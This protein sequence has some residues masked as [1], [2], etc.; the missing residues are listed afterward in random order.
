MSF[1]YKFLLYTTSI[2]FVAI[3]AMTFLLHGQQRII[4]MENHFASQINTAHALSTVAEEA[5]SRDDDLFALRYTKLLEETVE[6][7]EYAMII[8]MGGVIR[9]HSDP[10]KVRQ[11]VRATHTI[12][13]L[14]SDELERVVYQKDGKK[15]TEISAPVYLGDNKIGL[16]VIGYSVDT[17]NRMLNRFI[18]MSKNRIY[19]LGY[20]IAMFG[21]AASLLL[22]EIVV[23]PIKKIA[24]GTKRIGHG[25]LDTKIK[26][27]RKDELGDLADD[28]NKMTKKLGEIDKMKESFI[29]SVTHEL[30]SPLNS[31]GMYMDLFYNEE[32]GK[33]NSDQKEALEV[34]KQATKRLSRFINN[35]L[36]LSKLESG[37]METDFEEFQLPN[38]IED[39]ENLYK[40][41]MEKK[42]INFEVKYPDFTEI[43]PVYGDYESTIRILD[44]LLSNAIKFTPEDGIITVEVDVKDSEY[45]EVAVSDTGRGIPESEIDKI[46]DKFKQVNGVRK[47]VDGPKGTGLGLPLV[48][49]MVQAQG[50]NIRVESEE[51][52]GTTFYFTI[53]TVQGDDEEIQVVNVEDK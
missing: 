15:I 6:G 46:F 28:I 25:N 23:I 11:I 41:Q 18:E 14:N 39:I 9:A 36:D 33:I 16:A 35:I 26:I 40:V 47:E 4:F 5:L 2:I 51:G 30:R 48:K 37:Q 49:N 24:Y 42:N 22:T 20:A 19:I 13:S 53:P 50:G 31:I 44:N 27:S 32:L 52:E 1:K 21:I 10:R 45:L 3:A 7:L 29:S 43:P 8:N 17:V 38:L 34:M 12:T